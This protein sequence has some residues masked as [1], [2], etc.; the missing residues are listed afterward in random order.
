MHSDWQR[1]AVDLSSGEQCLEQFWVFTGYQQS[2][3]G[4]LPGATARF[5]SLTITIIL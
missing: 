3:L 4:L 5:N 1:S 2:D